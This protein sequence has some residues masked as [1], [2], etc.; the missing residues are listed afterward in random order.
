MFHILISDVNFANEIY[1]ISPSVHGFLITYNIMVAYELFYVLKI[2]KDMVKLVRLVSSWIWQKPT[3]ELSGLFLVLW[4]RSLAFRMVGS[5]WLWS[6]FHQFLSLWS[7]M[8]TVANFFPASKGIR[9]GDPL[10]PYLSLFCM[11]GFHLCW[12]NISRNVVLKGF[13]LLKMALGLTIYFLPM[14]VWFLARRHGECQ[15]NRWCY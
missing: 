9:Q 5:I 11:E 13:K 8:G 12:G 10:Y 3:T 14:I 7:S 15:K 2:K 6:A 1:H 4:W